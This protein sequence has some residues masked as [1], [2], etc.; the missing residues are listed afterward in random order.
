MRKKLFGTLVV[1]FLVLLLIF[2]FENIQAQQQF[3]LFFF[4]LNTSAT[5]IILLSGLIGFLVG[6]FAMV[7]FVEVSRQ[8]GFHADN[9][10]FGPVPA[11][12]QDDPKEQKAEEIP[13]RAS[14]SEAE[15][16]APQA[17]EAEK[18]DKFDEDDE[19]LG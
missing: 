14:D 18:S 8:K 19:V 17:E 13:V 3:L 7:Y 11:H 2:A 6:F 5:L 9:D 4:R 12:L 15:P 1:I 10:A 16:P